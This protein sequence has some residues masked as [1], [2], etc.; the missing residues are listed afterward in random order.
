VARREEEL[1]GPGEAG[2]GAIPPQPVDWAKMSERFERDRETRMSQFGEPSR[3]PEFGRRPDLEPVSDETPASPAAESRDLSALGTGTLRRAAVSQTQF[4]RASSGPASIPSRP[5]PAPVGDKAGPLLTEGDIE[6]F[7]NRW[8]E[9]KAV[10]VD[11][12][13]ASV[14]QADTL[15]EEVAQLIVR[16]LTEE[17]ARLEGE[18]SSGDVSTEDLRQSLHHYSMFFERLMLS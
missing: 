13:R 11:D 18:W 1:N 14:Q 15:V 5:A 16:R 7:R 4:G 2:P 17:R 8:P 3:Q 12:P 10:F 6:G 9:I